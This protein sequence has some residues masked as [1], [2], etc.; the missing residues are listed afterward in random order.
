MNTIKETELYQPIKTMLEQQGFTVK[1]EVKGC[2]IAAVRDD[3][4]WVVELKR[5]LS[6]KL[7]SQALARLS[8][9]PHVFVAVPRPKTAGK[10]FKSVQK[11]LAKLELGLITVSLD[12]PLKLAEIVLLPKNIKEKSKKNNRRKEEMCKEIKA[13]T[14]DTPGGSTKIKV[15]TAYREQCIKIAC[16]LSNLEK[17]LNTESPKPFSIS[18]R[19]LVKCWDCPKNTG[20]I[21]LNN[22]YGW[23]K[24]ISHGLYA[25][26]QEGSQY[27]EKNFDNPLVVH[28]QTTS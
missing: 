14:G 22:Y 6:I 21:L 1:G 13:S 17:N 16:T 25:L 10:D 9:T 11:I 27:L 23:F 19:D 18:P 7:L 4:L 26:S 28:Y 3:E 2:D 20:G 5:N 24:R 12:S 15:N 8:T